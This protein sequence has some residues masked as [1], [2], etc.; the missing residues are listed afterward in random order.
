[1]GGFLTMDFMD[2]MDYS[3]EGVFSLMLTTNG[4]DG[5]LPERAKQEIRIIL[6]GDRLSWFFEGEGLPV[7]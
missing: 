3:E 2:N 6:Q 5:G 1:M 4:Y 7:L